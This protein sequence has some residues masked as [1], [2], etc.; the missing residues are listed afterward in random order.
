MI[1]V[2]DIG[3]KIEDKILLDHI[4][5]SFAPGKFNLII[6][7]NGAGKST[8]IKIMSGA[9]MPTH[10][11]VHYGQTNLKSYSQQELA[12]HRAV[13]SQHIE[14]SFPLQVWEVVLMGRY[15]HFTGKPTTKDLTIC[16]DAMD[17]FEIT[18]FAERNY[19]SLSGGE[20]QRVQFAKVMAQIWEKGKPRYLFLDEPLTFLDV[21]YQY[22]FM[23]MVRELLSDDELTVVGVVH[24]LNLAAK[25]G[26]QLVL[27]LNGQI[28]AS[29]ETANVLTP[30]NIEAAYKI[31]ATVV[32]HNNAPYLLF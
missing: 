1:H 11:V 5:A 2:T 32:Y 25:Y 27:M 8:L 3:F 12:R 23:E 7:P 16:Q 30:E 9:L 17:Y 29:G 24:D 20:K 13:L 6:G 26:D 28:A 18:D 4:D 31:K 15:P 14:C 22:R 21:H 19:E 10:G